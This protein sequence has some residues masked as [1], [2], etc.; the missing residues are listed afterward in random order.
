MAE[1]KPILGYWHIRGLAQPLRLL[2]AYTGTDFEDK[3]YQCGPAPDYSRE[4]WFK[5]KFNLGLG[6]WP[7]LPYL[8]DG[9]TKVVETNAIFRYIARKYDKDLCGKTDEEKMNCDMMEMIVYDLR[10]GF[11]RLCY[12]P[13]FDSMRAAYVKELKETKLPRF[14]RFLDKKTW[15]CGDTLTYPDFHLYEMLDQHLLFEPSCLDGLDNLKAYHKRFAELPAIKAYIQSDRFLER[16]V[17]N[18]MASWK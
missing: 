8:I 7:G 9:D 17:N 16:P 18:P 14:S 11:V 1:K 4:V 3:R 12:N 2:L 15:L 6:E 13:N 5:E 10:N